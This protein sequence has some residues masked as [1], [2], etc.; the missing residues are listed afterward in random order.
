M[1]MGAAQ[2]LLD[3]SAGTR[4]VAVFLEPNPAAL[5]EQ[6]ELYPLIRAGYVLGLIERSHWASIGTIARNHRWLCATDAS[7]KS[8]NL[9]AFSAALR[10]FLEA[11]ADSHDV[12]QYLPNAL[13]EGRDYFYRALH[14]PDGIKQEYGFQELEDRLI[15]FAF[16]SKQPK[17]STSP[18]THTPKSNAEYIRTIEKFG[19]QG[20]T[21]LYSELCNLTH[22][23]APSLDCFLD[24]SRNLYTLN[25][26][27]DSNAIEDILGR[28][29]NLIDQLVMNSFNSALICLAFLARLAP[30][31]PAPHDDSLQNIPFAKRCLPQ[32]DALRRE[33]GPPTSI[34]SIQSMIEASANPGP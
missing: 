13:F 33:V 16:A 4:Y 7:I 32:F 20:A 8:S 23:A 15:H 22:P 19:A 30:G 24:S 27:K 9:L 1:Y 12:L 34:H 2:S 17:N 3:A 11:A 31:W 6:P 26:E 21:D 14:N 25:F 18:A 5:Q 29:R 10:G 28:N